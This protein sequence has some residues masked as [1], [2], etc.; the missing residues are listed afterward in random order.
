MIHPLFVAGASTFSHNGGNNPTVAALA[1]RAAEGILDY[2]DDP[3][4]LV[5]DDH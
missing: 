2:I 1:Y 5:E 4:L 3:R